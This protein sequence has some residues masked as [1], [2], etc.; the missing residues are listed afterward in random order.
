[1]TIHYAALGGDAWATREIL[2]RDS[3]L[4]HAAASD[5]HM[6]PLHLAALGGD[7]DSYVACVEA[8]L[9]AG[10]SVIDAV[11]SQ[12][13]TALVHA[14]SRGHVRIARLLLASGASVEGRAGPGRHTPLHVACQNARSPAVAALLEYGGNHSTVDEARTRGCPAQLLRMSL[15]A[16]A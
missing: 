9:R 10:S 11:D 8:L 2:R 12:G 7:G 4:A 16:A 5:T 15:V 14:V 6:T 13:D 3:T 1:M